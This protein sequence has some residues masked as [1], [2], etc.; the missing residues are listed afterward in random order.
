MKKKP[1]QRKKKRDFVLKS[2]FTMLELFQWS[3]VGAACK[4]FDPAALKPA[5]RLCK[6]LCKLGGGWTPWTE[7]QLCIVLGLTQVCGEPFGKKICKFL[8]VST[9]LFPCIRIDT[10]FG[11]IG[12][13]KKGHALLNRLKRLEK[14]WPES[15][16][17]E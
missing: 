5:D 15:G 17:E 4:D 3:R 6:S 8:K 13:T 14:A 2:P 9:D 10:V 7:E 12:L 1:K 11:R 16:K